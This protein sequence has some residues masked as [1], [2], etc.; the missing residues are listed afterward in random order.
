LQNVRVFFAQ[1]GRML[2]QQRTGN[3]P[4]ETC[5]ED[6]VILTERDN[7]L[8]SAGWISIAQALIMTPSSI[9]RRMICDVEPRTN[10]EGNAQ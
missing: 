4:F 5:A 10:S 2:Q 1:I 7:A 8:E 6:P 3:K 9:L